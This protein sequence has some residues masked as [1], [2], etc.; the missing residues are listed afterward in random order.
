MPVRCT[1]H[2]SD[3][4]TSLASSLFGTTRAG[5]A[6]PTPRTQER[7][8]A[9]GTARETSRSRLRT[10]RARGGGD[11]RFMRW[12]SSESRL[13]RRRMH[14]HWAEAVG[15]AD[16]FPNLAEKFLPHHVIHQFDRASVALGVGAA[17]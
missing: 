14:G 4:S 11:A 12:A 5:R 17:M 8:E 15:L 7:M 1:I 6:A 10:R 13:G 16:H 2:S 9:G 3:V